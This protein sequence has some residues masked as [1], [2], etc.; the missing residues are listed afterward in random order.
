VVAGAR[1]GSEALSALAASGPVHPVAVDLVSSD[2]PDRLVAA[3]MATYGGWTSRSTTS[4][5]SDL[6]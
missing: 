5:R 4:A 3:A 6:A 2:S 1:G